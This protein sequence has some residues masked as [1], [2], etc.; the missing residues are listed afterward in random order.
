MVLTKDDAVKRAT[1]SYINDV[2]IEETKVTA[3]KVRDHVNTCKLTT[4]LS[5]VGKRNGSEIIT[6]HL[7]RQELFSMC[8]KVGWSLPHSQM[9]A[10]CVQFY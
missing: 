10:D 2:L 6:D 5:V 4:K 8:E 7:T 9:A 1:S 3:E